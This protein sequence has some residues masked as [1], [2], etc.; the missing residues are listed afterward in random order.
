MFFKTT[1]I[2][3]YEVVQVTHTYT[4][5]IMDVSM[6]NCY[7]SDQTKNIDENI[8]GIVEHTSNKEY[9]ISLNKYCDFFLNQVIL[10][11]EPCS[12]VNTKCITK[13]KRCNDEIETVIITC[14]SCGRV[15]NK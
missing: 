10:R 3:L 13:Q 9:P 1:F 11:D 6:C 8:N 14:L 2:T 12:H 5:K 15:Q 7:Y 4:E